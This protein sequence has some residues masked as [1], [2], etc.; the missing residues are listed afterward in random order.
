MM[1][2]IDVIMQVELDKDNFTVTDDIERKIYDIRDGR[3]VDI[4][5]IR[6]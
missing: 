3:E 5:G 2:W 1:N 4:K 6:L